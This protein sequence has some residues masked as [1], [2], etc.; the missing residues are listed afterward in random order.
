M[1][2]RAIIPFI[3][4]MGS[5]SPITCT[6]YPSESKEENLLWHLNKMREHDG[7]SPLKN[8]PKSVKW[9]IIEK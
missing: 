3:P 7:L 5:V 1:K 9:E 2:Y 8:L 4:S 6:D